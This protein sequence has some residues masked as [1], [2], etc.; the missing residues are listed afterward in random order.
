MHV[1][2]HIIYIHVLLDENMNNERVIIYFNFTCAVFSINFT[3]KANLFTTLL[4]S[5]HQ[6]FLMKFTC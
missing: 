3:F 1:C 2:M 6:N 4:T 5:S